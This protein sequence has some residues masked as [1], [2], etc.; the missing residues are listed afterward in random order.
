MPFSIKETCRHIVKPCT[1][2]P[3]YCIVMV[4]TTPPSSHAD[5]IVDRRWYWSTNSSVPSVAHAVCTILATSLIV[6]GI[7]QSTLPFRPLHTLYAQF[8]QHCRSALHLSSIQLVCTKLASNRLYKLYNVEK[9]SSVLP[10]LRYHG[11]VWMVFYTITHYIRF[12]VPLYEGFCIQSLV[13]Y[14]FVY[15]CI[16]GCVY[17]HSLY[18]VVYTITRYIWFCTPLYT[19]FCIPSLAISGFVYHCTHGFVYHHSLYMVLYTIEFMVLYTITRCTWFC[20]PLYAWFC[21]PSPVLRGFVYQYCIPSS[22]L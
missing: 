4:T 13:I 19:W 9:M 7:D 10:K 3:L 2:S 18:M 6:V 14:G 21:I 1:S 22:S 5:L 8:W 11:S 20:I 16:H 15:H 17:H 12:C